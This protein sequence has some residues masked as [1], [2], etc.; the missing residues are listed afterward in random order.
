VTLPVEADLERLWRE[1]GQRIWRAVAA[2]TG[3]PETASD[4]V[5]EASTRGSS[6]GVGT[7]SGNL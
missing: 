2:Y 1:D 7:G 3:D 5:A 6:M 4:A